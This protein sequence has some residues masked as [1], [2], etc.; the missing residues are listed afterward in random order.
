MTP[1]GG[2]AV[3]S[4]TTQDRPLRK[5]FRIANERH[6]DVT[7]VTVTIGRGGALGRG[8]CNPFSVSGWSTDRVLSEI[9][10]VAP[11]VERGIDRPALLEAMPPGPARSAVDCALL[12]VE[13]RAAADR[14]GRLLQ[15]GAAGP[16]TTA[17]TAGI[18]EAGEKPDY[19]ELA[20][21][22]IVKIK[23]DRSSDSAVVTA[24]RAAA[25]KARVIVDANGS[26][27]AAALRRWLPVLRENA[28]D[29][30]EQPVAPG[31]D[32]CLAGIARGN[33]ALCADESF[34]RLSDLP[35]VARTY[36][37]VNVK[38]D[39]VGGV[40]AARHVV[41]LAPRFGLRLMVG[42]MLGTSLSAAPAWWLA[43]AAEIVDLDGPV[44]L[45]QDVD[46]AMRWDAG[47]I[48]E[49]VPELWG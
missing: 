40:T 24:L 43:Q 4:V 36:D 20:G 47:I 22:P 23:I 13:C 8:E 30:L 6:D 18:P 44:L 49:P 26:L 35:A 21:L 38:L 37:M 17:L 11:L 16:V 19:G 10:A 7:T 41:D 15:L 1:G 14:A 34:L 31:E 46:H 29:V 33:V 32:A 2:L 42:C 48:S 12:D 9:N 39:K 45:A 28:V 5:P 27:D 25:P 3:L